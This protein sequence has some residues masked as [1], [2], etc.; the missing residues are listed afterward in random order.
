MAAM[1]AIRLVL[2]VWRQKGFA[3]KDHLGDCTGMMD[4]QQLQQMARLQILTS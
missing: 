1:F 2:A 3:G 4:S